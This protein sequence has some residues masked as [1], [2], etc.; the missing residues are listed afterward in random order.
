MDRSVTPRVRSRLL[1]LP[2]AGKTEDEYEDAWAIA[3]QRGLYVVTDGASDSAYAGLWA[4]LL[5]RRFA[6]G[7]QE[8]SD[9]PTWRAW[10]A[11]AC[12]EWE[13][14]VRAQP[15]PWYLEPKIREG[16]FA[17]SVAL[18]LPPPVEDGSQHWGAVAVGDACVFH[19]STTGDEPAVQA[20]FPVSAPADFG[21]HPLALSSNPSCNEEVWTQIAATGGACAP[22]D[23]FALASDA[24]AH[25][26]LGAAPG[27]GRWARVLGW[28]E[29][30]DATD[31]E[32]LV[33]EEREA[34]RMHN[35]DMTILL[36]QLI[37]QPQPA[38]PWDV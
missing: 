2:K 33:S 26:L 23:I 20:C 1:R 34:G 38:H 8:A 25:W 21:L 30:E 10:I 5:A 29:T 24:M 16:A 36:A 11:P 18:M 32:Q 7:L 35:D 27:D 15:V 37:P 13:R 22:G 31:F 28:L 6:D 17:T 19:L 9:P 12:A 3:E 14:T 4:Q